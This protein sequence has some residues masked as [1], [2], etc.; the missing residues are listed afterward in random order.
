MLYHLVFQRR[1]AMGERK[2]VNKYYPP[3]FDPSKGSLNSWL[4]THPLRDRA[5]KLH[6][7]ILVIRFEMP[8]NIWCDGCN[9]HIGMGVRYNAEKSKVGN[10]YTTPIYKFRMKCHLCDNHFEIQTDP[11]NH[12]YVILQGARRKEQRWDP[13]ENEQ[14]VPEDKATQKK[15]ATDPMYKLEHGSDDKQRGQTTQMSVAQIENSREVWLDDYMLNKI[16]RNKFRE[17]KKQIAVAI[18]ADKALLDKSSLDIELVPENESDRKLASLMKYSVTTSFDEN[19]QKRRKAIENKPLFSKS[20]PACT[21]TPKSDNSFSRR[22]LIKHKLGLH[23]SSPKVEH[24][25]NGSALKGLVKSVRKSATS[26]TAAS[27]GTDSSHTSPSASEDPLAGHMTAVSPALEAEQLISEDQADR[28]ETEEKTDTRELVELEEVK[29][30]TSA[31]SSSIR[32]SSGVET[33]LSTDAS[34]E[35]KTALAALMASYSDSES[36]GSGAENV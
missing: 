27:G 25:L 1:I 33:S 30:V 6:K 3:D 31:D 35:E 28:T 8:Y 32:R 9:N 14:I 19:Q 4:G 5:R 10:Y 15:L 26:T 13:R 29:S 22:A 12:D 20:L 18:A 23:L 2:G 11:K 21:L 16:A 36:S 17:E 34:E 7:G 24:T